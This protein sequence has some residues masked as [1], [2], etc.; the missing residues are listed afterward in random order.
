[1][2][3][4]RLIGVDPA[5]G[6]LIDPAG[7]AEAYLQRCQGLPG[8]TRHRRSL[9]SEQLPALSLQS[10]GQLQSDVPSIPFDLPGGAATAG[11]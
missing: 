4:Q 9:A 5:S 3:V 6:D 11:S 10:Q 2:R 8:A 7:S 1:M